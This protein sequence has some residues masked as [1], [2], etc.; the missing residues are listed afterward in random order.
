M[1]TPSQPS[2][3]PPSHYNW[4][5][6]CSCSSFTVSEPRFRQMPESCGRVPVRASSKVLFPAPMGPEINLEVD[7]TGWD[8]GMDP[9]IGKKKSGC[10]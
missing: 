2:I 5:S 6:L 4:R 7:G 1:T 3:I 8:M 9:A 10:R